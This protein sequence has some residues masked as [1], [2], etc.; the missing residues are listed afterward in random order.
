MATLQETSSNGSLNVSDGDIN[1]DRIRNLFDRS[2]EILSRRDR[3]QNTSGGTTSR[4]LQG[5]GGDDVLTVP[6]GDINTVSTV[7]YTIF[8]IG[9]SDTLTGGSGD[10]KIYAGISG[11][12][13]LDGGIGDDD[14]FGSLGNDTL[15]GGGGN[16]LLSGSLGNDLLNGNSGDDT[17]LGSLGNDTL[18]GGGGNDTISGSV[19]DDLVFGNVGNDTLDGGQGSDVIFGGDGNDILTGGPSGSPDAPEGFFED[20]LVGGAGSDTLNGFGGGTEGS[21]GKGKLF[22]RDVLVGGGAVNRKGDII[23]ISGDGVKD[24]F[25]LGDAKRSYYTDAGDKDYVTILG[26][27]EGIDQ[28]QFSPAVK[29]GLKTASRISDLDTLIFARLPSGNDLIA[30]VVNVDLTR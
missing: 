17:L 30:I 13:L 12:S 15:N 2:N 4:I 16:D 18:S 7:S 23:D 11:N 10:D 22:E 9:G 29:Y 24:V 19:G 27:E 26:F 1:S 28:L 25:V 8:G 5:T 21:G 6:E 20:N 14:L 3:N